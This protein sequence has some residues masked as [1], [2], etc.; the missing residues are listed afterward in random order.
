MKLSNNDI[1]KKI[2]IALE[3]NDKITME[4]FELG[5]LKVTRSFCKFISIA[6]DRED[7]RNLSDEEL[8]IFLQGLIVYKRGPEK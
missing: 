8:N 3:L 4:I 2:K 1:Y 5:G 7:Y 6:S